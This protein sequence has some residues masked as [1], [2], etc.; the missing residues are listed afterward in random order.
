MLCTI[1]RLNAVVEQWHFT[2]DN[3]SPQSAHSSVTISLKHSHEDGLVNAVTNLLCNKG[4]PQSAQDH[5]ED[6]EA[7]IRH[8]A[9][10]AATTKVSRPGKMRVEPILKDMA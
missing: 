9:Y 2:Q 7:H 3:N 4:K 8:A 10:A 5:A 1:S 6:L